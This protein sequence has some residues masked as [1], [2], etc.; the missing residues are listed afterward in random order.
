MN[1]G[2]RFVLEMFDLVVVV[3]VVV[4]PVHCRRPL[5]RLSSREQLLPA[6]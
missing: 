4:S 5:L 2:D 1:A 3:V 6:D